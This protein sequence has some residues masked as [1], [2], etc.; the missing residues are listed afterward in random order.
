MA[1]AIV[2]DAED[3]GCVAATWRVLADDK[4]CMSA[5][6]DPK[7]PGVPCHL[8]KARTGGFTGTVGVAEDRSRCSMACRQVGPITVDLA[9]RPNEE[10]ALRERTSMLFKQ[11]RAVRLV[12]R[13][14]RTL[15]DLA[16]RP[17]VVE[18]APVTRL[19]FVPV[20]PWQAPE[21]RS[22][23]H[24]SG[25]HSAS[26]LSRIPERARLMTGRLGG[27]KEEASCPTPQSS[28]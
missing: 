26:L 19:S 12:D 15:V 16:S 17:K 3:L 8:S 25:A 27:R 10:E 23:H 13:A 1:I 11:A 14:R 28:G 5:F 2:A 9:K 22:S 4:V 24:L 20:I 21:V 7:V 18:G 6:D